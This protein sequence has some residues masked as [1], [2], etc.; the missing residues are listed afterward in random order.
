MIVFMKA[1]L[2][3]KTL[4]GDLEAAETHTRIHDS[5][6]CYIVEMWMREST[7]RKVFGVEQQKGRDAVPISICVLSIVVL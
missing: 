3:K 7:Q 5:K 2:R 6:V 1:D 4:F